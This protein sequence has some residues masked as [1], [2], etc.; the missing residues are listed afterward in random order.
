MWTHRSLVAALALLSLAAPAAI[1]ANLPRKSPEFA[2]NFSKGQP[3]L[4]S[5]YKGKVV[6]L[7]FILT[8]RKSV[9]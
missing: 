9:V 8:D 2:I 4:L 6:V 1:A 7:A 3:I 5:Q